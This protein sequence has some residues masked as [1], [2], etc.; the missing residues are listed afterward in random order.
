MSFYLLFLNNLITSFF[1]KWLRRNRSVSSN[2]T[3]N[4]LLQSITNSSCNTFTL[5]IGVDI[6]TV[7]ITRFIYIPETN[8]Y[9]VINRYNSIVLCE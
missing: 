9:I 7:K 4:S 5:I 2:F 1:K 8:N 6:K 3:L